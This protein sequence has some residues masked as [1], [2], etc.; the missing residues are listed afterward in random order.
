MFK[1]SYFLAFFILITVSFVKSEENTV[2]KIPASIGLYGAINVNMHIPD[3]I[4]VIDSLNFS[5]SGTGFGGAFGFT[6]FYPLNDVFVI[7][8]KIGYNGLGGILEQEKY[9]GTYELD[10]SI[11]TIEISP[12]LQIHNLLP[13]KNLYLIGGLET[14][15]PLSPKFTLTSPDEQENIEDKDIPDAKLRISG[16]IGAG[17][18]HKL[19]KGVYLSPELTYRINFSDVSGSSNF[20]TW[21]IPQIRL[22]V[23]LTFALES[24][25]EETIPEEP[26]FDIGF[27][28]VRYYDN[29]GNYYPLDRIK[30][31]DVKYTEQ[32]PIVPYVFCDENEDKAS[33]KYHVLYAKS[34]A[35]EFAIDNLKPDALS[36]NKN[37]LDIVGERMRENPEAQLTI[38]GTID[39]VNEKDNYSLALARADF[40]KEYLTKNYDISD[41]RIIVKSI[42]LPEKPSSLKDPDGIAEN[43]RIELKSNNP[44]ILE[45]I[46]IQKENQAIA[47]PNLIEFVPYV[48]STDSVTEWKLTIYQSGE[49]V[50]SFVGQGIPGYIAWVIIPNELIKS[51][52]PV[53]YVLWVKNEKGESK[54]SA[55]TIPVD[56]YSYTRK[57]TEE[58]PDKTI[59]KF[60]L[61]LFDFDDDKISEEDMEIINRDILP[62]INF[63][64]TVKIF[65]YT[66]RIGEEGYNKSLAQRRANTVKDYLQSKVKS[67]KYEASGVGESELL[68]DNDNPVGRQLSRTVQIYILTPR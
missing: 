35:G 53:E 15:I 13:A 57:K 40:A 58:L 5:N 26:V 65:G 42:G 16:I 23:S 24:P 45:P 29:E 39:S 6:G 48:E 1:F 52:I 7:S 68:F 10:A 27:K 21:Q 50:R 8:G 46:I 64:S 54:E 60:S 2:T 36:I 55:G 34:D 14:G 56:Y 19:S 61:I 17:Y 12:E 33:E 41:E 66:D 31:E 43:R 37:T 30:V 44:K 20:K 11:N 63:N 3:F 28:E 25:P 9:G 47:E 38:T 18:L 67:A 62:L 49:E 59:A 22:G 4:Y 51:E 32:Y